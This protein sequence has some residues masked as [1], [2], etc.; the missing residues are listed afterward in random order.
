MADSVVPTFG[1]TWDSVRPALPSSILTAVASLGFERMTPVQEAAIPAFLQNSDVIVEAATGSG[2]TLSFV[3]PLLVLL[4]RATQRKPLATGEIGA[5]VLSPTRELAKQ[6]FSVLTTLLELSGLPFTPLLVVGGSASATATADEMARVREGAA[7]ILVGTPGRLED[8]VCGRKKGSGMR[9]RP[10][11]RSARLEVLVLDEADRLLDMG[12]EASLTAILAALPKQRRTGLFSATMSEALGQLV[13]AG[14][15]NPVRVQVQVR[16]PSGDSSMRIPATLQVRYLVCPPDRKMAQLVRL[17]RQGHQQHGDEEGS[18]PHK[19]IVY[20][21]TCAAVDYFYRLLKRLLDPKPEAVPGGQPAMEREQRAASELGLDAGG[22]VAVYSLHGQMVQKK[23]QMTFDAFTRLPAGDTGVLL[24]TDLASRGLDIPDVDYVVQ[25]DPPTDPKSFA[26]R[27]GRTARAGRRG[28]AL[29]FLS[30]GAE[31]TY[32]DFLA[33]RKIPMQPAPYLW[34]DAQGCVTTEAPEDAVVPE[35]AEDSDDGEETSDGSQDDDAA[36]DGSQ[37]L[38]S[39]R[40]QQKR[41]KSKRRAAAASSFPADSRSTVLLE[42]LRQYSA[43]D[44]E[45]YGRSSVAFVSFVQAYAKHEASFIFRLKELPLIEAAQGFALLHLPSMPELRGR[46]TRRF[47]NHPVDTDLIPYLDAQR[48]AQRQVKLA[49]EREEKAKE[50][51]RNKKKD[52][53]KNDAWSSAKREREKVREIKIKRLRQKDERAR[54]QE[55][56]LMQRINDPEVLEALRRDPL[57]AKRMLS[58]RDKSLRDAVL[59]AADRRARGAPRDA[60]PRTLEQI[61][62]EARALRQQSRGSSSDSSGSSGEEDWEAV[63]RKERIARKMAARGKRPRFEFNPGFSD[64]EGEN[65]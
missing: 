64:E 33:V 47:V 63:A 24:A 23:R 10:S 32:V 38:K 12:F 25:W 51:G 55:E 35:P 65:Q 26:H 21:S 36:E 44:R 34:L 18:R 7:D 17:L 48:E 5:L 52:K 4:Q 40:K 29:V 58:G 2:K 56:E 20:F 62:A 45:I 42:L 13:R 22:P 11:V 1:G 46:P 61:V 14:L 15:R 59:L 60:E 28:Q 31:E 49:K 57:L 19:Y 43:G 3:L 50:K 27:C 16:G 41:K 8:V 30:P 6:T 53:A 39:M 9:G 54:E 37:K